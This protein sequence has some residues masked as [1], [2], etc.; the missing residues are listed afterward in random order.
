[1]IINKT[2]HGTRRHVDYK[3]HR[4][5]QSK[6]VIMEEIKDEEGIV[7]HYMCEGNRLFEKIA[8]D[9]NFSTAPMKIKPVGYKGKNLDGRV[10]E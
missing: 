7:T 6:P 5:S 8:Y 1:M 3:A 9:R 4:P 10:I 2:M